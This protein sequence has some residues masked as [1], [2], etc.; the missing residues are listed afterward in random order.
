MCD[1]QAHNRTVAQEDRAVLPDWH[2]V[3]RHFSRDIGGHYV[4]IS[5]PK[6]G[7]KQKDR[8]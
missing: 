5:M 7:E 4:L 1:S 2:T 6:S 8:H 3:V